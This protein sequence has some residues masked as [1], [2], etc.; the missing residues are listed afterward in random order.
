MIQKY[1]S[2]IFC[3]NSA[4]T[5]VFFSFFSTTFFG[6]DPYT[7]RFQIGNKTNCEVVAHVICN[8]AA[9]TEFTENIDPQNAYWDGTC[10]TG[11]QACF[12]RIM[13]GVDGPAQ[14][15]EYNMQLPSGTGACVP[16]LGATPIA[17]NCYNVIE[18]WYF[19]VNSEKWTF[20][21]Y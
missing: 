12:V 7:G 10:P 13:F 9:S 11:S 16:N 15:N 8:D 5:L 1:I 3:R 4:I 18:G 2:K 19:N 21:F 14:I 6:Q 17:D 20:D